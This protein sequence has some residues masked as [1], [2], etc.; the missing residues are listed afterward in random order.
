MPAQLK[1]P[2]ERKRPWL[3]GEYTLLVDSYAA[4]DGVT[5]LRGDTL[6]LDQWEATRLGNKGAIASPTSM[7]AV[8]ARTESGKG[9]ARDEYLCRMWEL[10]GVWGGEGGPKEALGSPPLSPP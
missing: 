1:R 9:T 5:Y 8:R 10:A 3:A 7:H 4:E 2:W 6:A